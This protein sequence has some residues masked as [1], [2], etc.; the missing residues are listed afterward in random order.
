MTIHADKT[1]KNQSQH[2]GFESAPKKIGQETE[3]IAEDIGSENITQRKLGEKA[4]QSPQVKQLEAF[5]EIAN[6]YPKT[7]QSFQFQEMRGG[8]PMA[9]LP[10]RSFIRTWVTLVMVFSAFLT[11]VPIY[12]CTQIRL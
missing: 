3:L 8:D 7:N 4:N 12:N 9:D 10:K 5:Q 11:F 1:H 6:H 2:A